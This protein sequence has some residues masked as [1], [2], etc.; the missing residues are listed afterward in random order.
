MSFLLRS[1][2][3]AALN[4]G[5]RALSQLTPTVARFASSIA[6]D[7]FT[8]IVNKLPAILRPI[9]TQ[10]IPDILNS[11][12]EGVETGANLIKRKASEFVDRVIHKKQK[13]PMSKVPVPVSAT[14]GRISKIATTFDDD[15]DVDL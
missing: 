11:I 3:P 13:V 6:R 15:D 7:G 12:E 5:S 10:A 8:P 4:L 9:A 1:I 2:L 14:A